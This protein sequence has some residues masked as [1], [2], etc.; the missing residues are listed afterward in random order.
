MATSNGPWQNYARIEWYYSVGGE[1]GGKRSVYVEGYLRMDEYR[2]SG[3]GLFPWSRSGGWGSS[4]GSKNHTLAANQRVLITSGSAS[5]TLTDSAQNVSF[6][7][8]AAHWAISHQADTSSTLTVSV[9]ARVP[10]VPSGLSIVRNS[11]TSHKLNW[12]RNS[13]YT[14]VVV[15]RSTDGGAWSQVGRPT[16]NAATFTDTTTQANRQYQYRVA[17]VSA[18]GQSGWSGIETVYTTPAAPTSVGAVKVGLDIRVTATGLPPYAT[19]YDVYDNGVLT[20]ADVTAFPWVD[21]APNA[22]VTHTYTVKAKRGALVSGFSAPSNTVQLLAAPNAPTGLSPNGGFVA[23]DADV[24]LAWSH[25]PVDT[26]AQTAFELEHR[27][28]GGAWTTVAG[29]TAESLT[30]PF[31]VGTFEW[32]VRTKGEHPDWSPWSATATVTVIDRPGVAVLSPVGD[33][34]V[35]YAVLDW[36][37]FQAQGRPQ[38]AWRAELIRDGSIVE[39]AAGSGPTTEHAFAAALVDGGTYSLR[40]QAA[41]GAVWSAWAEESFTTIFPP[42]AAPTVVAEWSEL[43]GQHILD[44][45]PGLL[46][47]F[48]WTGDENESPSTM[49]VGESVTTNLVPNPLM[50]GEVTGWVATAGALEW[51]DGLSI[52]LDPGEGVYID[53]GVATSSVVSVRALIEA[54]DA[55][56]LSLFDPTGTSYAHWASEAVGQTDVQM[57]GLAVEVGK[58]MRLYV[59]LDTGGLLRI[60]NVA[61]VADVVASRPFDGNSQDEVT[62]EY[63]TVERSL[64]LES[65]SPV[66]A[67]LVGDSVIQ[68]GEGRS[69]GSTWYRVTAISDLPSAASTVVEVVSDSAALWLSGGIGFSSTARLPFNPVVEIEGGRARSAQRYEGRSLP[70]AYAGEQLSRSVSAS[71]MLLDRDPENAEVDELILLAQNESALHLFRDPDGRIIYG[72]VSTI[73]IPRKQ[74]GVWGYSFTL[75]ESDH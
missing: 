47:V 64:D 75:E 27:P 10:L 41:T 73:P 1:S 18:G 7:L 3:P 32:H 23:S 30:V 50:S 49:T 68:D 74:Y 60:K 4:S 67:A 35:A 16:G 9:P 15:Q 8:T 52:T 51:S 43:T 31:D 28:T 54:A 44:I 34:G 69:N 20:Q 37:W 56:R 33:V 61:V 58:P 39:S 70:V 26:T 59:G 45:R 57:D 19:A 65:W 21:V 13:T 62:T 22:A 38:S 55:Y 42:P 71:G 2:S 11:D 17:G 6:S 5:V 24:L 29:T 40:V 72:V 48:A 12:S 14:A 53:L 66:A 46:A 36:S 25:N 63:M